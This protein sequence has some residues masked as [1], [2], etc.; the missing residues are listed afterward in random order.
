VSVDRTGSAI[1][2]AVRRSCRP[3]RRDAATI[4]AIANQSLSGSELE[5]E[6]GSAFAGRLR[7][8]SNGNNLLAR[9]SLSGASLRNVIEQIFLPV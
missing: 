4:Q 6:V 1:R 7:D 5:K 3:A 2:L 8:L 9:R